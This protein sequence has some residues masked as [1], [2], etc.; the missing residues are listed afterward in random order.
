[1]GIFIIILAILGSGVCF[2]IGAEALIKKEFAW[3]GICFVVAL[4]TLAIPVI[5]RIL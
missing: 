2:K 4:W 3:A 5:F 1:M